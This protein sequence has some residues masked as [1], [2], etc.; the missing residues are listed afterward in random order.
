MGRF[1]LPPLPPKCVFQQLYNVTSPRSLHI[2]HIDD[3]YTYMYM[4]MDMNAHE[5]TRMY[6]FTDVYIYVYVK[7]H[8]YQRDIYYM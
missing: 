3:V 1:L 2:R 7:I 8:V 4:C 6:A 5:N